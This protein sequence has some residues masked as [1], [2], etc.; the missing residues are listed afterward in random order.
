MESL[1][2]MAETTTTVAAA[3][4]D[5]KWHNWM[6]A[7]FANSFKDNVSVTMFYAEMAP[8]PCSTIASN[9]MHTFFSFLSSRSIGRLARQL[10]AYSLQQLF[11]SG[12]DG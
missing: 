1:T 3:A 9:F 12:L 2:G 4:M 8:P 11:C 10:L 6:L 5:S 7:I